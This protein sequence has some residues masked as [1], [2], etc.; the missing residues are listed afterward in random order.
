MLGS[1]IKDKKAH[2]NNMG[3]ITNIK[4]KMYCLKLGEVS[5]PKDFSFY[6]YST[7]YRKKTLSEYKPTRVLWFYF[8]NF[9]FYLNWVFCYNFHCWSQNSRLFYNFWNTK[10]LINQSTTLHKRSSSKIL[11][12]AILWWTI[13]SFVYGCGWFN[14]SR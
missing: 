3:V 9:H 5:K 11:F 10:I 8:D 6:F 4:G 7:Q 14:N 2:S 13:W 12:T 1:M